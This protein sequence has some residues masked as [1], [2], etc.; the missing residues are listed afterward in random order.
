ML[1]IRVIHVVTAVITAQGESQMTTL[2]T[3]ATGVAQYRREPI[4]RIALRLSP[5]LA[6]R[7]VSL[8]TTYSVSQRGNLHPSQECLWCDVDRLGGLLNGP[9]R[10]QRGN[11]LFHL[12]S[13][14]CAMAN[15]QMFLPLG[16]A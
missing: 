9:M 1:P 3:E 6:W 5:S 4:I 11:C 12:S 8:E 16:A 7:R 15:H 13:E 2:I 14:F 10:Q